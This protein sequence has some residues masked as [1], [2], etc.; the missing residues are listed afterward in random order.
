MY[1]RLYNA[2]KSAKLVSAL[3]AAAPVAE[4]E[5][6]LVFALVFVLEAGFA[7]VLA[8]FFRLVPLPGRGSLRL[9]PASPVTP[10]V[11]PCR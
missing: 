10:T 1:R 8:L 6:E 7:P 3:D 5:E 2:G 11:L 4:E 9:P